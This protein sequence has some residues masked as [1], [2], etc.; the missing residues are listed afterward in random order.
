[1]NILIKNVYIDSNLSLCN[2]DIKLLA[3]VKWKYLH[4]DNKNDFRASN[5]W[6]T[7]RPRKNYT[8]TFL[9]TFFNSKKCHLYILYYFFSF[10]IIIVYILF[11]LL[12]LFLFISSSY[13]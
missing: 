2:E 8:L 12:L 3:T 13:I 10:F 9:I 7:V 1:M 4:P 6:C 5:G 11:A